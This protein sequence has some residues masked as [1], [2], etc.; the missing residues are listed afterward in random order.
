MGGEVQGGWECL[1]G[2][3]GKRERGR[4]EATIVSRKVKKIHVMETKD[5]KREIRK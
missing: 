1:G 2:R 4:G 5:N 3:G